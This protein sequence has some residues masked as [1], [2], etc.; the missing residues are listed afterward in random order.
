MAFS[1]VKFARHKKLL[2]SLAMDE[3]MFLSEINGSVIE[4]K[5]EPFCLVLKFGKT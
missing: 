3:I 1:D 5:V 4:N 2:H